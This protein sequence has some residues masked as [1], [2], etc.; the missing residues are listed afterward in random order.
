[1]YGAS[2]A[3]NGAAATLVL[4]QPD[5]TQNTA[6]NGGIGQSTLNFPIGNAFDTTGRLFVPD[7]QNNRTLVF[8]PP[9]S[10]GMNATLVLGQADFVTATANTGGESAAT[11]NNPLDVATF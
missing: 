5:F 7:E 8:V 1:M 6:N 4:G 11:Q 3:T 10:N 9:F 2:F